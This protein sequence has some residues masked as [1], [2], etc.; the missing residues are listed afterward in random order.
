MMSIP[1][2]GTSANLAVRYAVNRLKDAELNLLVA[3]RTGKH[4]RNSRLLAALDLTREAF[5]MLSGTGT[6][7]KSRRRSKAPRLPAAPGAGF[8]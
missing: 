7:N 4:R 3:M 2:K 8:L 1:R 5:A 6:E